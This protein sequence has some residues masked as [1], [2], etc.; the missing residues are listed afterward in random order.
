LTDSQRE[1]DNPSHI[2]NTLIEYIVS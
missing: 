1:E 2:F